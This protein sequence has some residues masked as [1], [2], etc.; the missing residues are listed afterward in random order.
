MPELLP[1]L[2]TY[3]TSELS[4]DAWICWLVAHVDAD[5][6]PALRHAARDFVALLWNRAHPED[7]IAG[8]AIAR[9][10]PGTPSRQYERIDVLF[11]VEVRGV[12]TVFVIED[13]T[14]TSHHSEQ[15]ARYR[16]IVEAERHGDQL[17]LVYLKTGHHF[18]HDL[19]ARA[20][21]YAIVSLDDL[22]AFLHRHEEAIESDIFRDYARHQ[23]A[24][25][26][27]RR[28]ATEL[29]LGGDGAGQLQHAHVQHVFLGMLRDACAGPDDARALHHG[30]SLGGA[31]WA[32]WEFFAAPEPLANGKR[33]KLFHRVDA[34]KHRGS[35]AF[36]LS[37]RQYARVKDS[38]PARE[39]KLARLREYRRLFEDAVKTSGASL[40]FARPSGD[41]RGANESEIGVLFFDREQ[42]PAR[43]LAG[44]AAVHRAFSGAVRGLTKTRGG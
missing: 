13:K 6:R 17:V 7:R 8:D 2:F 39:V 44:Y 14:G 35:R 31:P 3:A 43:V 33:E 29:L 32:N 20:A 19:A 5:A 10:A 40:R 9:L 41:H 37:T 36:Y 42:T 22:V 23:A 34:R 28:A 4:Q 18:D 1:N 16:A 12:R 26:R 21:G 11:E 15:L 24:A 38:P 25:L 30:T 27:T